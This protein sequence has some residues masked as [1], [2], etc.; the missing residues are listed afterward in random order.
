MNI[1]ITTTSKLIL[2]IMTLCKWHSERKHSAWPHSANYNKHNDTQYNYDCQELSKWHSVQLLSLTTHSKMTIRLT[3]LSIST[4]RIITLSITAE[5]WHKVEHILLPCRVF[6]YGKVSA[7]WMS[8]RQT[9]WCQTM[10]PHFAFTFFKEMGWIH[11]YND[12]LGE[13]Y[14]AFSTGKF[15]LC[16]IKNWKRAFM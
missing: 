8:W 16:L 5:L 6:S 7:C 1:R 12:V 14:N 13:S 9:K 2:R 10:M 15:Y 4:I 3:K 11:R